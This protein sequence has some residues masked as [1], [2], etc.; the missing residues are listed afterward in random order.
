MVGVIQLKSTRK[1]FP[2]PPFRR[3]DLAAD[4]E[5]DV[6][7]FELE[8]SESNDPE[9]N[10]F[11]LRMGKSEKYFSNFSF[12]IRGDRLRVPE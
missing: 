6:D 2:P 7:D 4:V 5:V 8:Y 3:D 11:W 12:L 10:R 1:T 9:T